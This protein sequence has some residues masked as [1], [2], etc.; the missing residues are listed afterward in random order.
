TNIAL[1]KLDI[2]SYMKKIPV[3]SKYELYGEITDDFPFP[4]ALPD[5]KPVIEYMDGWETDIS[6]IKNWD[7]LP[8]NARKYVEY[9]EKEIGCHIG[10][11]SVG[12]ERDSIIIR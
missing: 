11:V 6:K 5:A 10:Y 2:L 9:V 4:S 3:C 1:T 12:P 8:E 7:D